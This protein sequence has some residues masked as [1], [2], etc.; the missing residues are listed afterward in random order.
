MRIEAEHAKLKGI[1]VFAHPNAPWALD[2]IV[3]TPTE[4][5]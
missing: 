4:G 5:G 1:P 3:G 2:E